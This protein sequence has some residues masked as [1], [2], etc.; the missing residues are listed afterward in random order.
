V[1]S[2]LEKLTTVLAGRYVIVREIGSGGMATVYLAEDTRHHRK[3]AVKV[4]RPE[5]AISLGPERFLREIDIAAQLQH[6]NIL[7]LL[8]S[9]STGDLLY[10]VMPYI[11]GE[12][13]RDRLMREGELPVREAVR[14][15]T[16]VIDA[17]SIAHRRGVV[18]RDI[19]PGNVLLSDRHALVADFGVAK[20]V[21]EATGQQALTTA[22]VALGTPTYMAPEQAAAD[23]HIDHRA[24][25]YAVGVLAYEL[26]AGHPPFTGPSSQAVLMAHMTQI[27]ESLSRDRPGIPPALDQAVMRC[28]AK[29]PADRW[30]SAAELLSAL[31]TLTNPSG[32]AAATGSRPP[33]G[34]RRAILTVVGVAAGVILLAA[35]GAILLRSNHGAEPLTLGRTQQITNAA[36]LELD[37]ALSPDGKLIA[38]A[39]GAP[40]ETHIQVRQL[41]GGRPVDVTDGLTGAHRWPQW[42]PN[43]SQLLFVTELQDTSFVNVAPSFGGPARQLARAVRPGRFG[44]ASAVWSPDGESI[45]YGLDGLVVQKLAGGQPRT[46]ATGEVH[47]L[48]WSPDGSRLAYVESNRAFIGQGGA[49]GNIAPSAI[50]VVAAH[51]GTPVAVT[52]YESQNISPAW[53]TDGQSLLFVSNRGGRRDLYRVRL[54]DSGEPAGPPQRLTTGLNAQA[55][56]LSADGK[57]LA[58]SAVTLRAN[59]WSVR[60]STERG[61][62]VAEPEPVT[63]GNRAVEVV[64]A[65]P[66]GRWLAFDSD[67]SGNADIYRMPIAGGEIEQLTT[68]PADD[69]APAW[70]PDGT[71]IAFHSLRNGTRDLFVM[72][73]SGGIAQRVTD[74]PVHDRFPRWSPDGN[75]LAFRR[76]EGSLICVVERNEPAGTWG[77]PRCPAEAGA[78]S[79]ADWSMD[80]RRL[81]Y[82]LAGTIREL[83]IGEAEARMV[84]RPR[85]SSQDPAALAL[86]VTARGRAILFRSE[87]TNHTASFWS[88]PVTG[89]I[90]RMLLQFDISGHESSRA[91]FDVSGDRLFF[92]MADHESDIYI[93]EFQDGEKER[94]R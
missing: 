26:L 6:P 80:G 53:A 3:V 9:G 84:Y 10:Y 11:Q 22:G 20:A 45:A 69:F 65:S 25:I 89:G 14:I 31:E 73:A 58:Y 30:Q 61:V 91:D 4:L 85:N 17:L 44:I 55:L 51:G 68:D 7:P 59:V 56:S 42:S 24:D 49:F 60:L 32:V 34:V 18:H 8:D 81:F 93:V 67:E 83:S 28:L 33:G 37:P 88:I 75:R 19:K 5:L 66:D 36:G 47:S 40:S 23:P 62:S 12:S 27:P 13:L 50:Y 54:R 41:A 78:F 46:I 15:L 74:G 29:H 94:E 1:Q 52:S 43:G 16:E 77:A 70:S 39:V 21:S 63:R 72:P 90:P 71:E 38:Y 2:L 87:D 48:S 57:I 76:D 64:N 79:L 35:T 86:R 92:T 82:A